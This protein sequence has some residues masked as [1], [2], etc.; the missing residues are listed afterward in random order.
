MLSIRKFIAIYVLKRYKRDCYPF[1]CT[2]DALKEQKTGK[3]REFHHL[4]WIAKAKCFTVDELKTLQ[5][6]ISAFYKVLRVC[7]SGYL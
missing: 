6:N 2:V 5:N 3:R 4:G 1:I 7:L